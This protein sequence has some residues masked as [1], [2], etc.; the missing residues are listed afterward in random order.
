MNAIETCDVKHIQLLIN[1]GA[2]VNHI[3]RFGITPL[4]LAIMTGHLDCVNVLI[5]HQVNIY[6]VSRSADWTPLMCAVHY[7]NEEIVLSLLRAMAIINQTDTIEHMNALMLAAKRGHSECL[8]ILLEYG[9]PVND[10]NHNDETALIKAAQNGHMKCLQLLI[11]YSASINVQDDYGLTALMHAAIE[12]VHCTKILIDAGAN[13]E[14]IDIWKSNALMRLLTADLSLDSTCALLLIRAGCPLNEVNDSGD[15][16]LFIAVRDDNIN[17]TK[18]L[19]ERG[20]NVNQ[21][22][23]NRTA[24]W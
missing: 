22:V 12:N 14:L 5:D 24:L 7:N 11:D 19:I 13:L 16:A 15:T 18:E 8:K 17:V 20:A 4:F 10:Q 3:F 23:N 1:Q 6:Q 9:S 21:C 2:N